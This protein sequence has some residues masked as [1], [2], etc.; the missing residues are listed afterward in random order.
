MKTTPDGFAFLIKSPQSCIAF[1][2]AV[3]LSPAQQAFNTV[4]K[5]IETQ[6][7]KLDAWAVAAQNFRQKYQ[8]ELVPIIRQQH[9]IKVQIIT[10]LDAAFDQKGFSKTD[11]NHMVDLILSLAEPVLAARED[12]QLIQV[13]HKYQA[14]AEKAHAPC[15]PDDAEARHRQALLSQMTGLDLPCDLDMS[16]P[17]AVMRIIEA[18]LAAMDAAAEAQRQARQA[19]QTARQ[20]KT[21]KSAKHIEKE[22]HLQ[23]EALQLSQSIREVYR[24]LAS[25]LHPDREPNPNE[26]LRKTD[27]M[28]RANQAYEA[29]HLFKLLELQSEI[30]ILDQSAWLL[31]SEDRLQRFILT[32]KAEL[33]TLTAEVKQA[34]LDFHN[35]YGIDPAAHLTPSTAVRFLAQEIQAAR[36]Q[37]LRLERELTHLHDV[38]GV[39]SWLRDMRSI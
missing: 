18:Q 12:E 32:L 9:E 35:E 29:R 8:R 24:K 26:R 10:R 20:A 38:A 13:V 33:K 2:E 15:E 28:Q 31:L 19:A 5:Q 27:L 34:A 22:A 39:K 30:T 25:A 21:K 36:R 23:A 14:H 16:H 6:R 1:D 7:E 17:D 4:I 11:R 3:A 37:S